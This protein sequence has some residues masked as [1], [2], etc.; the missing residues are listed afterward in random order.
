[1][2]KAIDIQVQCTAKWGPLLDEQQ[3]KDIGKYLGTKLRYDLTDDEM[4][5]ELRDANVKAMIL[6][7]TSNVLDIGR[8]KELHDRAYEC[9]KKHPD[10]IL[11]FWGTVNPHLGYAGV[12]ELDRVIRDYKFV[13]YYHIT[14]ASGVPMNDPRMNHVYDLCSEAKVPVKL[15]IGHTAGGAGLPGGGGFH[16]NYEQPIPYFDDVC[17]N[18]PNLTCIS[19]HVPWPW[20]N[21]LISVLLHK[22]NAYAENHGWAPKYIPEEIKKEVNSRLQDKYMFASD[23]PFVTHERVFKEWDEVLKP[24]VREKVYW[25]NAARIFKIKL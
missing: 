9:Q 7:G 13:G 16:L 5:Q 3:T 18:F 11:G 17:A 10:V 21:E 19:G 25:K 22:G 15:N 12:R 4:A 1:M 8:V 20:H 6:L 2:I 14:L 24:E 23:Y